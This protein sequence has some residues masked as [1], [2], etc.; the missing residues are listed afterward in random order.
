M[1]LMTAADFCMRSTVVAIGVVLCSPCV[2]AAQSGPAEPFDAVQITATREPER[3]DH[4]P[5]SISIVTG[6]ELRARG[7]RDLRTALSLVAGVEGTPG[8]DGG[9]AG[10]VPALWGLRE[11]DAFLLVVDGIPWGGA[12][13][14]ATP[15]VDLTGVEHIEILRGAAPVM[16]GATSFVGVIHIIHYAAG[17]SPAT[18]SIAAGS[19]GGYGIAGSAN[20]PQLLGLQQSLTVNA[21]KRGFSDDR[22]AFSRFHALYRAARTVGAAH[23]H[24]DADVSILPQ[25]PAGNLLLRDNT[26]LHTEFPLQANYNPA[27]AKLNQ[28]RYHLV[29]ALDGVGSWGQWT[30]TLAV[31]R[32]LDHILRGFLRGDSFVDPPDAGVGDGLQA[33]GYSQT[34]GITDVYADA[35]IT[36]APSDSLNLTYGI[37]YLRGNGAQHAINL[38]YCIDVNGHEY[39]CDG[40][41]HADE[42]VRSDDNRSFYGVYTQLDWQFAPNLDVLAGARLNHTQES[43]SGLGV[44]NTGPVPVVA[45]Q[46]NGALTKTRLSGVLGV[47][48]RA[49]TDRSNALTWYADYRNSFK[50]LAIDFGPEAEVNILKPETANSY[51]AGAKL[52]LLDGK[53]DIDSSVFRMDFRN[54]RTFADDGSGK[55]VPVNG[56][57]TRFEGFE[58]ESRYRLSTRAQFA[59]HYANH[60]A[61]LVHYTGDNGVDVSG[62]RVAMSPQQTAGAGLVF[63]SAAGPG[64]SLIANYI[65]G[66]KLNKSNTVGVGGYA[67]LDA[68]LSWQFKHS[69]LQLDGTNLTDRRD[70]VAESELNAAATVTKTSGYYRLPGRGLWLSYSFVPVT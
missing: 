55:I 33:D 45:F 1:K 17:A 30:A 41:R 44:V 46:G 70:P 43:A 36:V 53:L 39:A 4:V 11:A 47:S 26:T 51:E 23:L 9:P 25:K 66:R 62:N 6:A 57:E 20:L 27:G 16:F 29:S 18:V 32:T 22:T 28:Q 42:I 61:R 2:A 3:V 64:G 5:A 40:A 19:N 56:G 34:R 48:W 14:P 37:D 12:F 58:I 38:G 10:A 67:T 69:R 65:G 50:P 21:E 15:S 7:A 31:T 63:T 49:W 52:Q 60:D 59:A 24:I 54:G 8:G 35:H 68:S 13:N